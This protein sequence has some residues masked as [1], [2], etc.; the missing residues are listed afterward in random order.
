MKKSPC[1][2]SRAWHRIRAG[3]VALLAVGF[4]G[5]AQAGS[6]DVDLG[7]SHTITSQ[8]PTSFFDDLNGTPLAGQNL[9]VDFSFLNNEFGRI[10]TVT[11]SDFQASVKLQTSSLNFVGFLDGTGYLTDENGNAIPGYGITGSASGS[12]GSMGISLFPLLKDADGTPNDDLL[13]PFDFYGVHFDLTFPDV[14]DPSIVVTGGEFWLS[15]PAGVFGV[16][17]GIP[18]NIVPESGGT[19]FLLGLGLLVSIGLRTYLG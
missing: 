3:I 16:G 13:R 19:L 4:A 5:I 2:S 15:S 7:P 6:I 17:P 1:C 9:A 12:D 18:D 14:N 8:T 10:F 11:S